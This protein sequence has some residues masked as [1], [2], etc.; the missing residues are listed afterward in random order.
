MEA[1]LA[2]VG[3]GIAA[4]GIIDVVI[5]AGQAVEGRV[6]DARHIQEHLARYRTFGTSISKGHLYIQLDLLTSAYRNATVPEELRVQLD[7]SFGKIVECLV[8]AEKELTAAESNVTKGK[9][10]LLFGR[11]LGF[12]SKIQ[13]FERQQ[14]IF[15]ALANL[16][17]LQQSVPPVSFLADRIKLRHERQDNPGTHLLR[18]SN[19][20]VAQYDA[21]GGVLKDV[22]VE[23]RPYTKNSRLEL[24]EDVKRLT[25]QLCRGASVS[26]VPP[27]LGYRKNPFQDAYEIFFEVPQNPYRRALADMLVT[28]PSPPLDQRVALCKLLAQAVSDV[29]R[30]GL[31]HKRIRPA[32]ILI[33]GQYHEQKS[34]Q[35]LYLTDWTLVRA[36][37]QSSF[38]RGE[39]EWQHAIYQHP[40]RQG[41]QADSR[42]S[43]KH[44]CYSLGIC[45]LEILLWKPLVVSSN[46]NLENSPKEISEHFQK[47]AIKLGPDQGVPERYFGDTQKMTGKPSVVDRV[48]TDLCRTEVPACAGNKLTGVV[49]RCLCGLDSDQATPERQSG[50]DENLESGLSYVGDVVV[51]LGGVS[52]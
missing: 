46:P 37:N 40:T 31:V 4:P 32:N 36:V 38:L 49:M 26:S 48:M 45:M 35:L 1:L 7:S 21:G 50:T 43:I 13:E 44:D 20:L 47:R 42:Y 14:D 52:I 3:L 27:C 33:V 11:Q 2:L 28:D 51:A 29:H 23:H 12:E 16:V 41:L 10:K 5:R 24:E 8:D 30:M 39:D 9:L 22:I 18:N 34:T 19:I 6:S 15:M 17:H 25:K